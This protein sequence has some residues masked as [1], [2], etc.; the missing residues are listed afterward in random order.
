M[1]KITKETV[2]LIGHQITTMNLLLNL[3]STM[4]LELV[5]LKDKVEDL[6][7]RTSPIPSRMPNCS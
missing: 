7:A 3:V 6:D 2:E 4:Q 1:D 5:K